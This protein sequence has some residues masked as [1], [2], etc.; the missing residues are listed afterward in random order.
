MFHIEKEYNMESRTPP[1]TRM[2]VAAVI[3]DNGNHRDG[4]FP[5][6]TTLGWIS[7]QSLTLCL[8]SVN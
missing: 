8:A 4:R 5:E 2:P 7:D 6:E 1:E 3:E